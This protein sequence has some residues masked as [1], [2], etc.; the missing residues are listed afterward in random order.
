MEIQSHQVR[1]NSTHLGQLMGDLAAATVSATLVTPAV[2]I[3]DRQVSTPSGLVTSN[4]R[5]D[6]S[7]S[8][9]HSNSQFSTAYADMRSRH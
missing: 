3:I 8:N 5:L 6:Q 1:W 7:S 4:K 9:L 2:A